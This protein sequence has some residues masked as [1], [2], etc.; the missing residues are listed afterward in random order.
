MPGLREI[1][2]R[3]GTSLSTVSLVLNNRDSAIGI[4]PATRAKVLAAAR[5]L[6][7]TPNVAARRLRASGSHAHPLAIGLIAPFDERLPVTIRFTIEAIR[8]ALDH[9]TSER[10]LLPAE[11]LIETY[12]AGELAALHSLR[13]NTR[14]N[15]A[16]L[17]NTVAA[18]DNFLT[19][20]GSLPL[21]VVVVQRTIAGQSWVNVDNFAMGRRVAAHLLALGH[22]RFGTIAPAVESAAVAARLAGFREALAATG[23]TL[24]PECQTIGAFAADGGEAA[25]S[26]LIER[27]RAAGLGLPTALFIAAD[28]M[29]IG[30]MHA[31]KRAGLR[32]PD[33]IAIIGYDNDPAAA[34][35]DPPLT[36]VEAAMA[37]AATR[38]TELLL[39]MIQGELAPPQT[40]LLATHL[41]V[42]ASCGGTPAMEAGEPVA[43][44]ALRS[45]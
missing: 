31:L 2:Q 6:G 40:A 13:A 35:A 26:A 30:A 42:R 33:D 7:Y 16:I 21:P 10:G 25:A 12:P 38:A 34:Y 44:P 27:S 37:P 24:A 8:A 43:G 17:F 18:D 36:T 5:E 20:A 1:A 32:I 28:T 23:I 11:L 45:G 39:G 41:I 19:K 4:S 14:Y 29:A 3:A 9:W 15:G 22:R